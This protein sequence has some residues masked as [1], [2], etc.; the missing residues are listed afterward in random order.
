[1]AEEKEQLRIEAELDTSNLK[2]EAEGGMQSIV[3]AEKEVEEQSNKTSEAIDAIG[4]AGKEI[5]ETI[6]QSAKDASNALNDV[7]ESGKSVSDALENISTETFDNISQSSK[8]AQTAIDGIGQSAKSA[9]E[10]FIEGMGSAVNAENEVI[11]KSKTT[12]ESVDKIGQKGKVAGQSLQQGMQT[13]TRAEKTLDNQSKQTSNAIDEIGQA[14]KNAGNSLAQAG[15][16]GT[17]A[18]REVGN[19]ADKTVQKIDEIAEATKNINLGRAFGVAAHIANSDF[20]KAVGSDIGDRLGMSSSAQG[21]AGGA[22]TGALGGAAM[23]AAFGPIGA[24]GGALLGAASG[25]IQAANAQKEAARELA[26]S[27]EQRAKNILNQQLKNELNQYSE[28]EYNRVAANPYENVKTEG[29][30]WYNNSGVEEVTAIQNAIDTLKWQMDGYKES[31]N[32][33]AEALRTLYQMNTSDWKPEDVQLWK[34]DI[35]KEAKAWE[36]YTA[37]LDDATKRL[38]A[39]E[40]LQAKLNE[41]SEGPEIPEHIRAQRDAEEQGRASRLAIV[42]QMDYGKKQNQE[43]S[44]L[45]EQV[46]NASPET[47]Q[48][49]QS[50][51]SDRLVELNKKLRESIDNEDEFNA[52]RRELMETEKKLSTVNKTFEEE[53]KLRQKEQLHEVSN[54]EKSI[55][56]QL[57]SV[58]TKAA[59]YSLTDSLTNI[60]GGKGYAGQMN[61]VADN[62]KKITSVLNKQLEY[63]KGIETSIKNALTMNNTIATFQ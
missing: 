16:A 63:L 42:E 41:L 48:K 11:S 17:Q 45:E 18:L 35:E 31:I 33:S 50:E 39:F 22:I 21:L 52:T 53:S 9:G 23:G 4:T 58:T 27:G 13:A 14:G 3:D 2:Q 61:G 6:S 7:S 44:S 40:A 32:D 55:T 5:G 36:D 28:E 57:N 8:E 10:S 1:M 37:R 12:A 34:D 43:L 47:F 56:D 46:K 54:E 51:L 20:G 29:K 60:G 25:L 49:I 19:E 24:A 59:S 15:D 62:V 38:A 30:P 26:Q